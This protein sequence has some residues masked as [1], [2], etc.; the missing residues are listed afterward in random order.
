M[1]GTGCGEGRE[2]KGGA[3][4]KGWDVT[5]LSRE[6]NRDARIEIEPTCGACA[7][8]Y[9]MLCLSVCCGYLC[10]LFLDLK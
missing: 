4:G 6:V 5:L 7:V 9:D 10:L 3:G 8:D 2:K 1:E